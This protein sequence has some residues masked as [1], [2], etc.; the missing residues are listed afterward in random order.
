MTTA[1]FE[2]AATVVSRGLGDLDSGR[3]VGD[4]LD[5]VDARLGVGMPVGVDEVDRVGRGV[6]QRKFGQQRAAGV[7]DSPF[8][9]L[10]VDLQEAA[11]DGARRDDL[12]RRV[13]ILRRFEVGVVLTT[14]FR[15]E[16]EV[17]RIVEGCL[18]GG[19][20]RAFIHAHREASGLGITDLEPVLQLADDLRQRGDERAMGRV[21]KHLDG[22]FGAAGL[23]ADVEGRVVRRLVGVRDFGGDFE[24]G[25]EKD[26][27]VS[28]SDFD[29]LD[30]AAGGD[31]LQRVEEPVG[32]RGEGRHEGREQEAGES[33]AREQRRSLGDIARGLQP[34]GEPRAPVLVRT[35]R[36]KGTS[37]TA[38][39]ACETAA[40]RNG[41]DAWPFVGARLN[42]MR[43]I[44]WL[45][46][47]G[48]SSS[49]RRTVA[50]SPRRHRT[51]RATNAATSPALNAAQNAKR[52]MSPR[53]GRL[54]T[55]STN[56]QAKSAASEAATVSASPAASEDV[57]QRRRA[58]RAWW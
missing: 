30:R 20:G 33:D 35:A 16:G 22:G 57:H 42:W 36:S 9:T 12:E 23:W 4:H 58:S 40:K 51:M 21:G 34:E 46:S 54:R 26:F 53:C 48:N 44:R 56:A 49:T 11:R 14:G 37:A 45:S 43:L 27:G 52:S 24:A 17:S 6:V 2:P 10:A 19:D 7:G 3:C 55:A 41:S 29:D 13:R 47:S 38:T 1:I 5:A 25:T 28:G 50:S 8:D 31:E 18:D 15:R 39:A 32:G